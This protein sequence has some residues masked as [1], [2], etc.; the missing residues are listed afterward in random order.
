LL[1]GLA[2]ILGN[3]QVQVLR[4]A[5]DNVWLNDLDTNFQNLK[6]A[7]KL[8]LTGKELVEDQFIVLHK[9]WHKQVVEPFSGARYF[10]EHYKV[11]HSD[12][13]T[14]AKPENSGAIPHRL[15]CRFILDML[16]SQPAIPVATNDKAESHTPQT[17]AH[18]T[19]G[20]REQARITISGNRQTGNRHAIDIGRDEVTV[21]KNVQ[22]GEDNTIVVRRETSPDRA[23]V[24]LL[25]VAMVM[26]IDV[27]SARLRR[28]VI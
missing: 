5:Q 12:H 17:P 9:Y 24:I 22:E 10:G 6:E 25:I 23:T 11:P 1:S 19:S 26:G 16:Q 7:G 2:R 20:S 4:F 15:L 8:S 28:T 3:T 13:S 27:L 21:E 18:P 14:I